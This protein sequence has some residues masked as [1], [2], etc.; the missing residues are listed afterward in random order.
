M[1]M[2]DSLPTSRHPLRPR[3]LLTMNAKQ[4]SLLR[5]QPGDRRH[6]S[7][8]LPL[9]PAARVLVL[10]GGET[11][12]NNL[13][14]LLEEQEHPRRAGSA[15]GAAMPAAGEVR[16]SVGALSAG[17]EWPP[18]KLAV[19]TEGQLTAP[20]M[21]QAPAGEE[22]LQPAEAPVLHRPDPR[23]PGGPRAPRRGPVRGH[24]ADAGGRRG[25]GL[26]QDRLRRR[27]L[28]VRP[29]DPAGPGEQVHR[30]RRGH[31]S[32][33]S[34][35]SWAAPSGPS[36]RPR[37]RRPP[38]IWPRGLIAL[39]A[40]R[41]KRPGFA[42]SPDSPWQREF[43]ESFDYAETD[44]QLR[45][46]AEIKADMEKP[47]PM[48]RLLCGDVGYGK[49]EVALRA[50]MKCILDGKQAAILVPT[51]VLAQQHYATAVSRF[52]DF[53]GEDRGALPLHPRQG[54]EADP[55]GRQ[56]RRRGPADRHPQAAAEEHG[57]QRPGPAGDRRGAALRRH[58]QGAAQGDEPPGGR[59]DPLRHPHPPDAEHGPLGPAGHVH[60][61]GA[62]GGPPAGADL[63][64]GARLGHHWRMPSAGSWA[65]AARYT[66]S[67]TGWRAID[68]TAARHPEDA[69]AGGPY[70]HRPREDDGAGAVLRHAG[71]GGRGGGHPGVH[72]HHRDRHRHPQRQHPHHRGRGQ[73]GA[74]PAPPDP[75]PHRPQRPAGLRLSDLPPGQ[76]ARRRP[77]PSGWR[78]SGSM[79]SSAPASRSPCGTWRSGARATC[80]GRS[81]PAIS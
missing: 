15:S 16:I 60:P 39:Y 54:A 29:R 33:P 68:A 81:S 38:R 76:G 37:P 79:W 61:G 13:Q 23:R 72:H 25:E 44:D 50:V 14:R 35:T 47:R 26:H 43:E 10:C 19:L 31:R 75:G 28:P 17:S 18:L 55:G 77:P 40:E 11:R 63:C 51:T 24:P 52:R 5:R 3:G 1:V 74:G 34:S 64:A 8:A 57:V 78:P 30:R 65:G 49:T 70:R 22:G 62:P 53:P 7:G 58:P 45:C 27:G 36:R 6:G 56:E 12:A 46:I 42:F 2:E 32:A 41:Q 4:L 59:A 69:G 20:A 21:R 48:D 73:D 71:H 66:T 80:W 9:A 67:T